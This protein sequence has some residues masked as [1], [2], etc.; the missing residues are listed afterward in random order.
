MNTDKPDAVDSRHYIAGSTIGEYCYCGENATH[1]VGEEM[2]QSDPL[3]GQ[4]HNFTQYV[5]CQ[6]FVNIVG[7]AAFCGLTRDTAERDALLR[8]VGATKNFIGGIY[9][10]LDD[11]GNCERGCMTC[12]AMR[13]IRGTYLVALEGESK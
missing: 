6:C 4:R 10:L 13:R 1:K 3:W 2:S 5:C 9:R 12:I 8:E 7:N 11:H